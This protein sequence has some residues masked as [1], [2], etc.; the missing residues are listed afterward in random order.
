M[1]E[2]K[3]M[4]M[5]RRTIKE[6]KRKSR[7]VWFRQRNDAGDTSSWQRAHTETDTVLQCYITQGRSN[8]CNADVCEWE[9]TLVTTG[10]AAG[11]NKNRNDDIT[12]PRTRH[13]ETSQTESDSA[14]ADESWDARAT[15][16]TNWNE[17]SWWWWAR[18]YTP[19]AI[20]TA[21]NRDEAEVALAK[22]KLKLKKERPTVD[23]VALSKKLSSVSSGLYYF[24]LEHNRFK[25]RELVLV[26]LVLFLLLFRLLVGC[27]WCS[28]PSVC[29]VYV[30]E[31]ARGDK[32]NKAF[33]VIGKWVLK[34][35]KM[36]SCRCCR[37]TCLYV[38]ALV[39]GAGAALVVLFYRRST[40][41]QSN[42]WWAER[43][44]R[45]EEKWTILAVAHFFVFLIFGDD[46]TEDANAQIC[47]FR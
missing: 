2:Q 17:V 20:K 41:Q 19:P 42:K 11:S 33:D 43:G 25:C 6:N 40:T 22:R 32:N 15:G 24:F 14:A 29:C 35:E 38:H 5:A 16:R 31:E 23:G 30:E 21:D 9:S 10:D 27:S 12:E 28:A 45:Q 36:N 39:A 44:S 34:R 37:S 18:W 1:T 7:S 46:S 3:K 13:F 47:G 8:K 4:K 26:Q